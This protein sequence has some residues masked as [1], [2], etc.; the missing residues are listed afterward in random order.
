MPKA[1]KGPDIQ[2]SSVLARFQG[3]PSIF[4]RAQGVALGC[5]I[6]AF[7][8]CRV[9]VYKHALVYWT[10]LAPAFW[11]ETLGSGVQ[12]GTCVVDYQNAS[13]QS[14]DPARPAMVA[15]WSRFNNR[16]QCLSYSLDRGRTWKL[17]EKNPLMI[18]PERDLKVFWHAPARH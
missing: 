1:L 6:P 15:F 17:Y 9:A 18:I 4:P 12:S 2:G 11:D 3:L 14:P 16:T 7:Q 10:E 8:A 13:G 5:V